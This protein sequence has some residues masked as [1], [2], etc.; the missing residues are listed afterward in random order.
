MHYPG[1]ETRFP[2]RL[3][4][5]VQAALP[6]SVISLPGLTTLAVG[7]WLGRVGVN[8]PGMGPN[9]PLRGCLVAFQ[10]RGMVFV[11]ANDDSSET[12]FTV[13]HETAHFICH[14]LAP[15]EKAISRLGPNI[16]NV[17]DGLRSPTNEERLA[18]VLRGCPIG[19]YRHMMGRTHEGAILS[20]DVE[21]AETEADLIALELLAP[22]KAIARNFKRRKAQIDEKALVDVIQH[23]YQVP[24]WGAKL[25]AQVILRQYGQRGSKWLA[26][27]G[28]IVRDQA[29]N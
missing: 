4:A 15:R 3:E 12:Q 14:Y 16:L 17:L 27:L 18:G 13:A 11:E 8:T 20:A 2:R 29:G 10:G 1:A 28:K 23:E 22:A 24:V 21:R 25:Q 7:Q 6:L 26:G 5:C 9:R 19:Q